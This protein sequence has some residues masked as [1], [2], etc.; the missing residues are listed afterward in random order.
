MKYRVIRAYGT[1]SVGHV[2]QDMPPNIGREL[3]RRGF[4]EQVKAETKTA[5]ILEA[6]VDRMMRVNQKR[7]RRA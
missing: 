5:A 3:A 7:G 2:F 1:W 4:L 6:P